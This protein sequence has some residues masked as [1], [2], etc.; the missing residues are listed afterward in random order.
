MVWTT[1]QDLQQARAIGL[2]GPGSLGAAA[3][4]RWGG[5]AAPADNQTFLEGFLSVAEAGQIFDTA[6][7]GTA[8]LGAANIKR[9]FTYASFPATYLDADIASMLASTGRLTDPESVGDRVLET[10]ARMDK[11]LLKCGPHQ[12]GLI[13]AMWLGRMHALFNLSNGGVNAMN[14]VSAAF[15]VLTF[16]SV[17]LQSPQ[18]ASAPSSVVEGWLKLWNVIGGVMGVVT[19]GLPATKDSAKALYDLILAS[20]QGLPLSAAGSQLVAAF[21]QAFGSDAAEDVR[22]YGGDALAWDLG[23][24]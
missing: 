16:T 11:I 20:P 13:R 17:A 10:G 1:Q 5:Q 14:Q 8:L 4:A 7:N 22:S 12:R 3:W 6:R 24:I 9:I 19:D 23:L 15:T 18:L 2:P 21:A